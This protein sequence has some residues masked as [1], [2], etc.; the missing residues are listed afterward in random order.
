MQVNSVLKVDNPY[1]YGFYVDIEPHTTVAKVLDSNE[2]DYINRIGNWY[3]GESQQS[4]N[5]GWWTMADIPSY[6]GAWRIYET[7][8]NK[9][10]DIVCRLRLSYP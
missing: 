7:I 2:Y 4:I 6:N 3:P 9:G 10:I 8:A 5:I 1:P